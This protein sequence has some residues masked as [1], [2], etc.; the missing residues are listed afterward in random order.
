MQR[1][2]EE[3]YNELRGPVSAALRRRGLEPVPEGEVSFRGARGEVSLTELEW[4]LAS[5]DPDPRAKDDETPVWEA[6][7]EEWRS[8]FEQFILAIVLAESGG[9]RELAELALEDY[10]NPGTG[11]QKIAKQ[12]GHP[13]KLL[14]RILGRTRRILHLAATEEPLKTSEIL[15]RRAWR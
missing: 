1:K 15:T 6:R 12:S 10:R 2:A 9:T 11:I 4:S 5:D 8:V 14:R 7:E 13:V 3:A